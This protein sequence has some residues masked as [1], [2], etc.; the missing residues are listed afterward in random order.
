MRVGIFAPLAAPF[1]DR[2]FV[3]T[4]ARAA[5]EHGFSSIWLG[6]HVIL[7]PEYESRYP[8][9]PDGKIPAA[10]DNGM[11]E[12]FST[13]S[14]IAGQT[15]TIRLGT[16]ICLVPQRNPVYTAKEVGNLDWLSGGRFDFGVGVGWL[17]EEYRALGVPFERR[18]ARCRS[19]VEVMK[20]LWSGEPATHGD[21]FCTIES[22]VQTPVPVQTPHPPIYFG[23]ES[24]PA[25]KRVADLGQ[26]W[27]PFGLGPEDFAAKR[28]VL[29]G[30]L[31]ERGRSI[32]DVDVTLGP[33]MRSVDL[34]DLKRYRDAGVDQVVLMVLALTVEDIEPTMATL[35]ETLVVPAADL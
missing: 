26:G 10:P 5:E 29:V 32:D 2:T 21:D 31:E 18:G 16:A 19:Y 13:L 35:A 12:P 14:F 23:G 30:I 15:E 27:L 28:E 17:E 3:G 24:K 22:A 4:Y 8:Y 33:Y 7:F 25:M 1:A 20:K 6:E 34:D 11:L 9:S